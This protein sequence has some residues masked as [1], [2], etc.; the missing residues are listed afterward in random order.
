M[1]ET[2]GRRDLGY[3]TEK[4]NY[5]DLSDV[6]DEYYSKVED[7]VDYERRKQRIKDEREKLRAKI[8]NDA[9]SHDLR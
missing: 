9:R 3:P 6:E 7:A 2:S 1:N 5:E 8:E 4:D